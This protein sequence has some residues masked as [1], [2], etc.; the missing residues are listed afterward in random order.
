MQT[1]V[2][3]LK[4]G[5]II[6]A[7]TDGL[8]DNVFSHRT[9]RIVWDSKRQGVMPGVAAQQLATYA[10]TRAKDPTYLS[11]FAR[12]AAKAGFVYRGGKVDDITVVVS[13][14]T[15]AKKSGAGD[16]DGG[17]S[18]EAAGGG[19]GGSNSTESPV[20]TESMSEIPAGNS[21]SCQSSMP[22]V[23]VDTLPSA[24][25]PGDTPQPGSDKPTLGGVE[26]NAPQPNESS[27]EKSSSMGY[28]TG[29][30]SYGV[31]GSVGSSKAQGEDSESDSESS[32]T[33]PPAIDVSPLAQAINKIQDMNRQSKL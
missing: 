2:C 18:T 10:F 31:N 7:G 28:G 8:F 15:A 13:Y 27:S 3:K 30:G 24:A 25:S 22:G 14:V 16:A 33:V 32:K 26:I 12:A 6:V 21:T 29:P 23:P 4:P 20:D 9:A 11:P 1:F 5:D 17:G 19:G